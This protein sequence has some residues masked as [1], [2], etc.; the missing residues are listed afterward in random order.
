VEI[1]LLP[2]ATVIIIMILML[3]GGSPGGAAGGIKTTTL[4][5]AFAALISSFKGDAEVIIGNRS[6][7]WRSVLRAF[8]IIVIFMLLSLAGMLVLNAL[9]PHKDSLR[10]AFEVVS[11][12]SGTGLSMQGFTQ[13]LNTPGKIFIM[14]FMFIGR[15]GPLS[16]IL[17]FVGREKPGHLRYPQERVI[18]G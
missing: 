13:E 7:A 15:V 14:F 2:Q 16:I 9:F 5:V 6:I 10:S 3:I 1:G 12:L 18:V 4:A 11:A 8:T 17:F